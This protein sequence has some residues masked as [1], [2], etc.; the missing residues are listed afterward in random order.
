MV[1]EMSRLTREGTAEPVSRD[2]SLRQERE[3]GNII[4]ICVQPT[5]RR[6]GNITRL[7]HTLAV[8][9]DYTY[10]HIYIQQ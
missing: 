3:Q 1:M 6:I 5:T 8:R 4:I 9:D 10:I 7:I 2:Q